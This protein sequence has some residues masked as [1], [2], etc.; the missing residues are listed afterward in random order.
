MRLDEHDR[1]AWAFGVDELL[2]FA[3]AYQVA[4]LPRL[5][6]S[7]LH[8]YEFLSSTCISWPTLT[9]HLESTPLFIVGTSLGIGIST[10]SGM[11]VVIHRLKTRLGEVFMCIQFHKGC[12]GEMI[13]A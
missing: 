2:H 9:S 12:A 1:G 6:R 11:V 8:L 3:L 4:D 13:Q 7:V 10:Y 5:F